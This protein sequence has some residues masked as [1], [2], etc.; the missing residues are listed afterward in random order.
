MRKIRREERRR[1]IGRGVQMSHCITVEEIFGT[2][3][4]NRVNRGWRKSRRRVT[5]EV[6]T[7][8]S[9]WPT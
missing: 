3:A 4:D 1:F 6:R 5:T 2:K 8:D 9:K 7:A